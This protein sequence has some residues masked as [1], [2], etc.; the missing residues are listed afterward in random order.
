MVIRQIRSLYELG[1]TIRSVNEN[2]RKSD[3]QRTT[4]SQYHGKS[5]LDLLVGA[6]GQPTDQQIAQLVLW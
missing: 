5:P 4:F 2:I 6:P 1:K 3:S